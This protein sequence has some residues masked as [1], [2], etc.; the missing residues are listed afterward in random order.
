MGVGRANMVTGRGSWLVTF[1][2]PSGKKDNRQ[3]IQEIKPWWSFHDLLPPWTL[4][5]IPSHNYHKQCISQEQNVQIC[6]SHSNLSCFW[7]LFYYLL[8]QPSDYSSQITA[9]S[10]ETSDE[11]LKAELFPSH[12]PCCEWHSTNTRAW[13]YSKISYVNSVQYKAEKT[14]GSVKTA[15]VSQHF[16]HSLCWNAVGKELDLS[17][18]QEH[19]CIL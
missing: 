8:F 12:L 18:F 6:I 13:T 5:L 19:F 9:E 2:W 1:H 17:L 3:C 11:L 4:Y 15:I 7:Y 10:E 14:W 16:C